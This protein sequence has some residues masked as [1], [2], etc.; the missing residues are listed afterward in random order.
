MS[1]KPLK[2]TELALRDAH[3][4]LLATRMRLEHM[5]PIAQALDDIGYWSVEM[6]GGATFD[7]CVRFLN[8]DPWERVRT[9]KKLMPKTRFQMLLRGQN[10]VGYRH[11]ADD[12]V[13][14]FID[15]SC[16]AGIDVFRVFD[17]LNDLRNIKTS[18]D[19]IRKNG[20]HVQGAMCYTTSP[21]HDLAF[22]VDLALRL[23]EMNVDS[24]CIKDMA[25]LLSPALVGDL[26]AAI[27]EKVEVPI[28]LHSHT[29]SGYA[30][31]TL[32][33]A[34]DAGVDAV[35]TAISPLSMGSSHSP[36]ETIVSALKGTERDTGLDMNKLLKI[37]R[38]FTEVR[39]EYSKV[40][41]AFLGVD[42]NIL[43]SQVP[44]GMISNL[45]SQLKTQN[46]LH[47]LPEVLEE[48]PNC[49]KDMG[50][51]PLVTPT[52]QIVG[53]QAVLNVLMGRYKII[54]RETRDL[55]EGRYGR[56][57]GPVAP[58]LLARVVGDREVITVRPADLIEPEWDKFKE[59]TKEKTSIDEDVMVFALFPQVADDYLKKRG[60]PPE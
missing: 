5:T 40:D 57:P 60:T 49:R 36:T 21:M 17:A 9:L 19:R 26:V 38:H 51:P 23:R 15:L 6:W 54:S 55:V 47:R 11:Y 52:S 14:K 59:D 16:A 53:A 37:A 22:F 42:V 8:E 44:G 41:T 58:E 4:S 2:I 27:K 3:Q 46:A 48:L 25:G 29:T 45:E 56:L 20:K 39:K 43:V 28:H 18:V 33:K 24:I 34:I 50:Y 30:L 35:D 13:D 31:M 10:L 7:T 12:V 1:V 32:T